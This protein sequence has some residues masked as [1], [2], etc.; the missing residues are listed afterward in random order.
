MRNENTANNSNNN[1]TKTLKAKNKLF[2]FIRK[3]HRRI[4]Y[5]FTKLWSKVRIESKD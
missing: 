3:I 4:K 2:K 1:V 5:N